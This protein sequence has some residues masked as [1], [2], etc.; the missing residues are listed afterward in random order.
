MAALTRTYATG[1]AV[2]GISVGPV[3]PKVP[4]GM[5]APTVACVSVPV[6]SLKFDTPGAVTCKQYG[7]PPIFGSKGIH[8]YIS[9][10]VTLLPT[11]GFHDNTY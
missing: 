4:T 7:V 11:G 6:R 2:D 10:H 1:V 8:V 9:Y 5:I 3:K